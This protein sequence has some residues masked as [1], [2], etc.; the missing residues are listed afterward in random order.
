MSARNTPLG[1]IRNIGIIAHIDAGKTTTTERILYYSGKEHRM[2]EVHE[3][4]AIMDYMQ[5]EQERGITDHLSRNHLLLAQAPDK[6]DRHPGACRFHRRGREK[7]TGIGRSCSG[8]LR[9][10]RCRSAVRNSL[11]SG[12]QI[13]RTTSGVHQQT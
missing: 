1:N 13:S 2:G 12:R 4:T 5:D 11:A 8:I 6:S 7:P 9:C 3:G 10:G